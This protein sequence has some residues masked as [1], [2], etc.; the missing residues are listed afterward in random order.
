MNPEFSG[1][2]SEGPRSTVADP[3]LRE[4]TMRIF[5]QAWFKGKNYGKG[6]GKDDDDD[7]SDDYSYK[8]HYDKQAAFDKAKDRY[9][10]KKG[11]GKE[12]HKRPRSPAGSDYAYS[13]TDSDAGYYGKG[14]T[15][16]K[17]SSRKQ[18]PVDY[19]VEDSD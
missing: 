15:P 12:A 13:H 17:G 10:D 9:F 5:E 1:G 14:P 18:G 6:H 16:R 8:G 4:R 2:F 7:E 11:R 3:A 19:H